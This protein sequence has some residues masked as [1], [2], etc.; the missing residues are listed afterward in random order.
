MTMSCAA[1]MAEPIE[2]LSGWI[3]ESCGGPKEPYILWG[4]EQIPH[5]NRNFEGVQLTESI[6]ELSQCITAVLLYS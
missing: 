6:V 3:V 4:G 2:M 1:K 5:G